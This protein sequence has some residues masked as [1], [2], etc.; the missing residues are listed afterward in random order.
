VRSSVVER[1]PDKI[2]VG[3]SI[4]PAPTMQEEYFSYICD[5]IQ[6]ITE[7]VYRVTD[8]LSDKEPLKWEIREKSVEIFTVFLGLQNKVSLERDA[9]LEK[10]ENLIG[11][12][13][14]VFS[15]F[16]GNRNFSSINFKILEESYE[17]IKKSISE[18]IQK[19]GFIKLLLDTQAIGQHNGQNNVRKAILDKPRAMPVKRIIHQV[20]NHQDRKDKIFTIIQDKKEV[21]VGE[22]SAIFKECSEKTIQRDLLEMVAKGL[23]RKEGDKRWRK[24][25]LITP[26]I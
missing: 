14:A 7:A 6:K 24:Y 9:G 15:L 22:L 25:M 3:G 8:L 16:S 11:Q 18:E 12:L 5:R 13:T 17:K 2:E 20:R 4:P 10:A 26:Q 19:D 1:Y 23:L 21:T